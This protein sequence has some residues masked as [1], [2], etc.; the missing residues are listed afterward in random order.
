MLQAHS[1]KTHALLLLCCCCCCGRRQRS[2]AQSKAKKCD[3]HARALIA[4]MRVNDSGR[5]N[6]RAH[7]DA[8]AVVAAANDNG[9]DHDDDDQSTR[10]ENGVRGERAREPCITPHIVAFGTEMES[11]SRGIDTVI[12][13]RIESLYTEFG[14]FAWDRPRQ[15]IE[16]DTGTIMFAWDHIQLAAND[17]SRFDLRTAY[18][19]L[20]LLL[21][22][23]S[24]EIN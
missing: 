12:Y 13:A 22:A 24:E 17:W 8:V 4:R 21:C 11:H 18:D 9:D 2:A 19:G 6:S 10:M 7:R 16:L 5:G 1:R 14:A 23:Q 15:H 3:M 20:P